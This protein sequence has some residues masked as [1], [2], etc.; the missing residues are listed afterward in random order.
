M[1]RGRTISVRLRL[2]RPRTGARST[3]TIRVRVPRDAP[4]GARTLRVTGTSADE[5]SDP[6]EGG[7]DDLVVLVRGRA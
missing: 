6:A 2:R 4:T 5:G 7:G 3:R 1:R